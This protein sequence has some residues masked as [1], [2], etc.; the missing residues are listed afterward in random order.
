MCIRDRGEPCVRRMWFGFRWAREKKFQR[1]I[2]RLFLFG[3]MVEH[4]A[5]RDLKQIGVRVTDR[6]KW[7][8]G[9]GGHI[10][11]RIDGIAHNVSEAPKTPHLLEV[12]SMN[13]RNFNAFKKHGLVQTQLKHY[14]Q[15]MMY[16]GLS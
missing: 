10:A 9:W 13:A 12:K 11:G 1:R 8:N 7:V 14:V 6:Q 2:K 5:I 15:M 16:M 4:L 3:D